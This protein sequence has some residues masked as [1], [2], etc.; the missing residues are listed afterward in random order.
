MTTSPCSRALNMSYVVRSDPP[1]CPGYSGGAGSFAGGPTRRRPAHLASK[2]PAMYP[3]AMSTLQCGTGMHL[4]R[5]FVG[6]NFRLPRLWSNQVLRDV[7]IHFGGDVV[8]VSACDDGDEA[9]NLSRL[10]PQASGYHLTE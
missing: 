6:R 1:T 8:N 5:L 2:G 4:T 7:G 9:G 10:L 3:S